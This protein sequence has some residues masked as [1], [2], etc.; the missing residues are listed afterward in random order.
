VKFSFPLPTNDLG[1]PQP[2]FAP[3]DIAPDGSFIVGCTQ[4]DPASNEYAI[5]VL[6]TATGVINQL[7]TAS[8]LSGGGAVRNVRTDGRYIAWSDNGATEQIKVYDTQT[9]QMSTVFAA[10][11]VGTYC[12]VDQLYDGIVFWIKVEQARGI[13]TSTLY[14][15]D[16][17]IHLT[18]TVV[19]AQHIES[20][21]I[22]WPLVL[23]TIDD[24]TVQTNL[25][26]IATRKTVG[27]TIF[28]LGSTSQSMP[29]PIDLEA[30]L[31][32][33]QPGSTWQTLATLPWNG[34]S[35]NTF[36]SMA[37]ERVVAIGYFPNSGSGYG[38]LVVWDLA[39][40][41][42]VDV[43]PSLYYATGQ[44]KWLITVNATP[45]YVLRVYDTSQLPT[46]P[47]A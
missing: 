28:A 33:D 46:S 29:S 21:H 9:G 36:L 22:S 42:F 19:Q 45:P 41:R 12:F 44:G 26:D 40:H 20:A 18:T 31:H 39:Q 10:Q 11:V 24:T 14:M 1:N 4:Q 43:E 17:A 34:T 47:H 16:L 35:T 25:Y 2:G 15:S 27:T 3:C 5:E 38:S 30:S 37:N 8:M 7:A 6:T 13:T 32:A 23:Y